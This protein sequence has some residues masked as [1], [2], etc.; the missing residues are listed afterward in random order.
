[1]VSMIGIVQTLY[2]L[3]RPFPLGK[4]VVNMQQLRGQGCSG[5]A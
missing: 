4:D 1:V 5:D 2:F 3:P